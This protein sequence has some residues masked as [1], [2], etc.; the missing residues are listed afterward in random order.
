MKTSIPGNRSFLR[1]HQPN[2]VPVATGLSFDAREEFWQAFTAATGWNVKPSIDKT[3]GRIEIVQSLGDLSLDPFES[4]IRFGNI[5]LWQNG[6]YFEE[7]AIY[8]LIFNT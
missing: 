4:V 3:T 6:R 8:L 7:S 5:F 2:T 1:V